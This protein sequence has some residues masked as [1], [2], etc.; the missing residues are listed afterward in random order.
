MHY[1]GNEHPFVLY[2]CQLNLW[3]HRHLDKQTLCST[4][5][6]VQCSNH[7]N[8]WLF[9]ICESNFV[10]FW[11]FVWTHPPW[12]ALTNLC[13][14]HGIMKICSRFKIRRLFSQLIC[15]SSLAQHWRRCSAHKRK[16]PTSCPNLVSWLNSILWAMKPI[17]R[18]EWCDLCIC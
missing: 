16:L 4:M 18:F 6:I 12:I 11:L 2:L 7:Q 15:M 13:A 5:N 8:K 14:I 9:H 1:I 10:S 17:E 3:I